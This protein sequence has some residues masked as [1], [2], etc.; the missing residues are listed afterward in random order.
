ATI[1]RKEFPLEEPEREPD[2]LFKAL[3]EEWL[4]KYPA[5][6]RIAPNTLANYTWAVHKHL[7]PHFGAM[8]VTD[9][10]YAKIE[11]FIALKRGPNGSLRYP[12]KPLSDPVL[13]IA[14]VALALI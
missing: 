1:A 7:V 8:L 4:A 5:T 9:I 13:R 3:A 10:D 11:A 2:L 14:L 12:G 6:H